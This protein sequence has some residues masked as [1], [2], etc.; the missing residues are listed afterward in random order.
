[1]SR[2]C[3]SSSNYK[4]LPE[5]CPWSMVHGKNEITPNFFIKRCQTCGVA[6]ID[7][8]GNLCMFERNGVATIRTTAAYCLRKFC[9]SYKK[10][11][12]TLTF[13]ALE[14]KSTMEQ[15][16]E[17]NFF[18][19]IKLDYM[20]DFL[21]FT[22]KDHELAQCEHEECDIGKF[23][24]KLE[25][26]ILKEELYY[27]EGRLHFTVVCFANLP[28]FNAMF[29]LHSK[30]EENLKKIESLIDRPAGILNRKKE[31]SHLIN[32]LILEKQLNQKKSD[33]LVE[34]LYIKK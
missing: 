4:E 31:R 26:N 25:E 11:N 32:K 2:V 16:F 13:L 17:K 20:Q 29:G 9:K 19:S 12:K 5:K 15:A 34:N 30:G 3:Y 23:I 21:K 6:L 14:K 22:N 10:N 7:Y 24:K 27:D 8:K 28:T 1:M 33:A 18:L